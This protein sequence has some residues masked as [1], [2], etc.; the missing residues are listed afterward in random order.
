MCECKRQME[1]DTCIRSFCC[2]VIIPYK[3]FNTRYLFLHPNS[4]SVCYDIF[5]EIL[6]DVCTYKI[7]TIFLY[8]LYVKHV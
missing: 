1:C 8:S 7:L 2:E 4:V 5:N 6:A 3:D